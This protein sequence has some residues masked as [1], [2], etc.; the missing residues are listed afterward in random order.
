MA[1]VR[2]GSRKL[3]RQLNTRLVLNAIRETDC[4]S[5]VDITRQTRLSAGTVASVV[6]E[7][8]GRGY[9]EKIGQGESSVGRKPI[10]LRFN[11][12]AGY[13]ISVR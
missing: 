2:T 6:K 5:S 7:L 13:V 8:S 1:G 11:P 9:V 4:I 10:L 12:E 3:M